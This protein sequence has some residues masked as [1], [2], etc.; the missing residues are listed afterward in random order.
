MTN[1]LEYNRTIEIHDLIKLVKGMH[2]KGIYCTK[3]NN[4]YLGYNKKN[5][6]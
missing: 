6:L 2:S 5:K 3:M 1:L 4:K